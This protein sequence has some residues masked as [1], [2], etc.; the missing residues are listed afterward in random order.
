MT[1]SENPIL[2]EIRQ[3][4]DGATINPPRNML[5]FWQRE[6]GRLVTPT[7]YGDMTTEQIEHARLV[8]ARLVTACGNALPRESE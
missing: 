2:S 8:V 3:Y 5:R 1:S 6:Y 4:L 7:G